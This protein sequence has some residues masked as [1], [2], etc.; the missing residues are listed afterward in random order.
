MRSNGTTSTSLAAVQDIC[1]ARA[2]RDLGLEAELYALLINVYRMPHL[3]FELSK[4]KA[5]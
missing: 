1:I 2:E 4:A 5:A 3:L